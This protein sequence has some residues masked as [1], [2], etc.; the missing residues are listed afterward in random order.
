[1]TSVTLGRWALSLG[2]PDFISPS[3][4]VSKVGV[5]LSPCDCGTARSFS[6]DLLPLRICNLCNFFLSSNLESHLVAFNFTEALRN[7]SAIPSFGGSVSRGFASSC[8]VAT[9]E[10]NSLNDSF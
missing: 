10:V 8:R 5:E 1:M 7:F 6:L 2:M 4:Y 3:E 9:S